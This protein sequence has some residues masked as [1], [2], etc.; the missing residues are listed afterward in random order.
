M[1]APSVHVLEYRPKAGATWGHIVL[2]ANKQ[3][4]DA[5]PMQGHSR[6]LLVF[7]LLTFSR[8]KHVTWPNP[9]PMEEKEYSFDNESAK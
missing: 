3:G 7:Y 4:A 1:S 9:A 6:P 5:K 2:T 8:A